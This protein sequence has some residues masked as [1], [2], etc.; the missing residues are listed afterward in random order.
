[1]LWNIRQHKEI[2]DSTPSSNKRK[3]LKLIEEIQ[4]AY[5]K[6]YEV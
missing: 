1:M 2:K 5:E 3:V 4:F 6:D